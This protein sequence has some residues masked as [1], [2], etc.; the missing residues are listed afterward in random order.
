[1]SMVRKMLSDFGL[2]ADEGRIIYWSQHQP[3]KEINGERDS[4]QG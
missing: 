2:N 1:M 4:Y 3:E